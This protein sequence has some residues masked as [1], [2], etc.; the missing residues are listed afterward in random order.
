M[1]CA[2]TLVL[3]IAYTLV[4][5]PTKGNLGFLST[6]LGFG[7]AIS[8]MTLV[9]IPVRIWL[10]YREKRYVGTILESTAEILDAEDDDDTS[11]PSSSVPGV[12][13]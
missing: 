5:P 12:T 2:G 13:T 7:G 9:V 6:V 8:A 10:L 4:V 1:I 3:A 11:R